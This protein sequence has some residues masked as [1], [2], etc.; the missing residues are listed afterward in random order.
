M[1]IRSQI[2]LAQVPTALIILFITFFFIFLL[3][4]I[5]YKADF[6]LVDN[7]TSVHSIQ[8]FSDSA[9]DLNNYVI[10]HPNVI[11]ETTKKMEIKVSQ[12]LIMHE[13]NLM[14]SNEE[15]ELAKN[16]R[17]AWELYKKSLDSFAPSEVIDQKYKALKFFADA[18]LDFNQD[19]VIRKKD[20]LSNFIIEY[21]SFVTIASLLSLL[22]GFILSWMLTGLALTPLKKMTDI[23]RQFGKTERRTILDVKGSEEIEQLSKEFN[24]MMGRLDEYH[25][26]SLGHAIAEYENLKRAFDAP[27]YPLLIFSHDNELIFMNKAALKVFKN[28]ENKTHINNILRKKLFNISKQV[29]LTHQLYAPDK[30]S[31]PLK[32]SKGKKQTLLFPYAYPMPN[33]TKSQDF[34]VLIVLRDVRL[35]SADERESEQII[36][37]FIHDLHPLLADVEM[38]IY[39]SLQEEIGPLTEKQKEILYAARDRAEEIDQLYKDFLKISGVDVEENQE[40]ST[41]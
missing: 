24:L 19:A 36:Q 20:E 25:Q 22:F 10:Q 7:F 13:K 1:K 8:K 14:E 31:K 26:S 29:Q 39:T 32:I 41:L 9:E 37:S 38:A 30:L 21:R 5:H 12:D 3:T 2:I 18:I 17:I 34:R 16:L 23:V 35:Q 40:N 33:H 11:D 15:A 6:I 27:P 4:V 28:K